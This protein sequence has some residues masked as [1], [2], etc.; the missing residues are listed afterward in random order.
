MKICEIEFCDRVPRS[1]NICGGHLK[2][3]SDG[4]PMTVLRKVR[5]KGSTSERN[6]KGEKFCP[7]C[8]RWLEIE[9][10]GPHKSTPDGLR[11]S[12]G[13]CHSLGKYGLNAITYQELY[14][15]QQGFCPVC[16]NPLKEGKICVD[17]DH[18]CCPGWNTCGKCVRGLL[19][20]SCNTAEGLL[21]SD[22]WI[23]SN[24]LAYIQGAEYRESLF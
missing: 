15:R 5:K 21:K 16:M 22:P 10:F 20:Y 14:D 7:T 17:H 23:I 12:C 6:E 18:K 19:C 13:K 11:R 4:R 8:S 9:N 24:L 1:G 2:Q 3:I